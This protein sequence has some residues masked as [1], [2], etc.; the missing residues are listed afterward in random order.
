M[1]K[2]MMIGVAA[3]IGAVCVLGCSKEGREETIDRLTSAG[4]ALNGEYSGDGTGANPRV[5]KEQ[6]RKE[7]IRQDTQ[8]TPENR[9][10]HPIEYCQ[11]QLES[12]DGYASRLV[13]AAHEVSCKRVEVSRTLGDLETRQKDLNRFLEEAKTVY[14]RAEAE[15]AW[16]AEIGGFSL[17]R[18]KM[19]EK[20]VDA[21]QCVSSHAARVGTLRNQIVHLDKR[22]AAILKEQKGLV[23]LRE[24]VEM[25]ISDLKLKKV[26]DGESGAKEA[27]DAI[28]DAMGSLGYD[29]DDPSL[30]E[31]LSSDGKASVDSEFEKLMSM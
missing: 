23:H 11:S 26:I 19:R 28:N 2:M 25:T 3:A 13:V 7:R 4:R 16:P 21:A 8:W 15:N 18:E 20:M 22:S 30:D 6:Q 5:V 29:C 14:R 31:I 12:I 10:L 27:L 24:K 17:S 1:K 9:A